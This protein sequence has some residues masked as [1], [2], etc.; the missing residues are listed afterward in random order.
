MSPS[1]LYN[2]LGYFKLIGFGLVKLY[3]PKIKPLQLNKRDRM[4]HTNV[5]EADFGHNK[6]WANILI[7]EDVDKRALSNKANAK[8]K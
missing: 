6:I 3:I 5:S 7:W 4:Q 8:Y 1:F 2:R